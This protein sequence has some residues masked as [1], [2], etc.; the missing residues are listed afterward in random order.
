MEYNPATFHKAYGYFAEEVLLCDQSSLLWKD[1]GGYED[2]V[3]WRS[4]RRF[5]KHTK[6]RGY[7]L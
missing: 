1:S 7:K 3:Y 4:F 5:V 2:S 6:K